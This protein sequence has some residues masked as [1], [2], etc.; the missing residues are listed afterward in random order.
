[1]ERQQRRRV[2]VTG[3]GALTPIGNS[4]QEFW[5]AMMEGRS[6]AGP[7]TRFDASQFETRF[8]CEV[9]NY[10]PL[11][12]MS[13]KEIQRMDLFAQFAMSATVM[14]IEDA[15]LPLD[16]IDP[17]RVGVVV[18]SGVGGMW[19]YHE[20]QLRLLE[21]GGKPDRISPYFV[22]MFIVDIV[23]GL[24]AIRYGFKGPNYSTVSAC[25]TSAHA[26]A[27]GMM[28]IQRGIADVVIVGGSE[29]AICPMGVAGFNAM[30]ALSTRND[31]PETASRPFDAERDGFVM[32]EGAG[33]LVLE[34][35]DHAVRRNASKIY[36]ELAGFGLS[37]DAYH[38][39]Q[40]IPSGEGAIL[41]MRWA[42]EDAGLAPT[43]IDYINA[44]GTS[45]PYNDKTETLAIKT[46]FGEHAYR[47]AVSSTKSMTGHLLGAAGVVEAIATIL[48]I[49]H[50]TLPPT[51]NYRTPDPECD[52][53]YVPNAPVQ[54]RVRA[55]LSNAFGFGGHNATL[56]F[57][58]FQE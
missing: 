21:R 45:T 29:A 33:I 40:P 19:T 32:G 35:L 51:I 39:T 50:Q 38:I 20:Q 41:S 26:I 7:I 43:D 3:M 13:R 49:V 16:R 30:K 14:A 31:S 6:G 12:H 58:E 37:D 22:P 54:R 52:L 11:L 17:Y 5:Q 42:L 23:P 24:I 44:H 9:K 25:A 27:D 48:A 53:F 10:D 56:C 55:A 8:A 28:L 46:L 18:G 47:L 34:A 36:A 4:V 57:T 2:V 15:E 1:M